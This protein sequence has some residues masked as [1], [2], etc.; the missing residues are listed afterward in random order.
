MLN[1][2]ISSEFFFI[3]SPCLQPAF[4]MFCQ[5]S[6]EVITSLA[7]A[8]SPI[9]GQGASMSLNDRKI[10]STVLPQYWEQKVFNWAPHAGDRCWVPM[11]EFRG[12]TKLNCNMQSPDSNC[13]PPASLQKRFPGCSTLDKWQC[14]TWQTMHEAQAGESE[15]HW[16]S[17]HV[18]S[19][20]A[21]ASAT[22]MHLGRTFQP[23]PSICPSAHIPSTWSHLVLTFC[24]LS[25]SN[26][27]F[28]IKAETDADPQP[29]ATHI[30]C[31]YHASYA[32]TT[33]LQ[34]SGRVRHS[35]NMAMGFPLYSLYAKHLYLNFRGFA[36]MVNI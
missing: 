7:Q 25:T 5:L 28:V 9:C 11:C 4:L 1:L 35:E 3:F 33:N 10:K 32:S 36:L 22:R 18:A 34:D 19:P 13:N 14:L 2:K 8:S 30:H 21:C 23:C 31:I 20:L 17:C 26:A 6:K 15:W 27:F 29:M 24:L 12:Q 16:H